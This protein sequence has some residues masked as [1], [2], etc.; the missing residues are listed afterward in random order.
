MRLSL[1]LTFC[2][3]LLPALASAADGQPSSSGRSIPYA[4]LHAPLAAVRQADPAG[5]VT[6]S[7][8]AEAAIAGQALPASLRIELR[9]GSATT[10][11][12]LDAHGC[13]SLPTVATSE[14]ATAAVWINQPKDAVKLVE[15]FRMRTPTSTRIAYGQLMESLPVLARIR[16]Q[17]I[18]IGNMAVRAAQGVELAF[19][20]ATPQTV[21]IGSGTHA[22]TWRTDP[23]GHVRIPFDAHLPADTQVVLGAIPIALQPYSE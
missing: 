6:Q 8:C 15:T 4:S 17:H 5:I 19:D 14:A 22:T 9:I 11:L 1:A 21:T 16:A 20:P 12:P 7:L 13:I 18:P 23:A 2:F 3:L 10:N